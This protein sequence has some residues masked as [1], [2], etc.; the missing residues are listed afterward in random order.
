M[1]GMDSM[2][3]QS[4]WL[5]LLF[6]RAEIARSASR[7]L[8]IDARPNS[9]RA[10]GAPPVRQPEVRAPRPP[11]PRHIARKQPR[12]VRERPWSSAGWRRQLDTQESRRPE[13]RAELQRPSRRA[14]RVDHQEPIDGGGAARHHRFVFWGFCPNDLPHCEWHQL[15]PR[16]MAGRR[17]DERQL[18][19]GSSVARAART[20]LS[21]HGWCMCRALRT[22]SRRS[23]RTL[24]HVLA[25]AP[26]R[27]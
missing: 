11:I 9:R 21:S 26:Q 10:V 8:A 2:S 25:S 3:I 15:G 19:A 22:P 12:Y 5:R 7:V 23:P 1:L 6:L 14:C 4:E 20:A 16:A 17:L 18:P 27:Q 13:R 24:C